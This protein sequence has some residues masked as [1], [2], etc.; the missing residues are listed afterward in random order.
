MATYC[1]LCKQRSSTPGMGAILKDVNGNTEIKL[2]QS[3]LKKLKN[4]VKSPD[5][6]NVEIYPVKGR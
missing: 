2:C 6:Q 5:K 4:G 1:E 3:C